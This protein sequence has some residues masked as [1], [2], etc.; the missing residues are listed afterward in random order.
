M[1]V[2][3]LFLFSVNRPC[4]KP[5]I[6]KGTLQ[7][8]RRVFNEEWELQFYVV[9]VKD[10]M[11]CLLCNS[12]I[13]TVKKYNANQHYA[14]H[15]NHKHV[16][17]ESEAHKEVLKKMKFQNQ[18]LRQVFQ[19]V[20]RQGTNITEET[21]RIAYILRKKG[22]P[23][24]DAKLVK[25]CIIEA[26]SCFDSNKV[27]KYNK[28]LLSTRTTT[29][30]QHELALGVSERLYTLC[31]NEDVYYSIA[32]EESIDINDS[33]Q[34]LFFIRHKLCIFSAMRSCWDW[35]P[36]QRTHN[37]STFLICLTLWEPAY[38]YIVPGF[39]PKTSS[40]QM[41]YQRHSFSTNYARE[42]FKGS[43]K[44]A[45]LLVCTRKN[46]LVGCCGFLWVTS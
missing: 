17:L 41:L 35:V 46:F 28:L 4:Q 13:T 33:A 9:A 22:K 29:D 15:W 21:H 31:Q 23:Y 8:E 43:N 6:R 30:R 18:Q 16:A 25:D 34:V 5:K 19:S 1:W 27:C 11:M 40:F 3:L 7:E 26:V 45:S 20:S 2:T 36:L 10:K 44:S 12:M 14:T 38:E 37:E 32:L 24:S 39:Q 42:L